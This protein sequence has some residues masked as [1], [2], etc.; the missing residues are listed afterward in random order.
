MKLVFRLAALPCALGCA[1]TAQA[2]TV[3][4]LPTVV[5]SA[6]RTATPLSWQPVSVD[7]ISREALT[8]QQ[9]HNIGEALKALPNVNFGGGPR[10]AGQIP[11]LRGYSGKQITVL[12]DGARAND[13]N[14]LVTPIN[15]DPYQLQNIEVVRGPT[16]ALYGSGGLGGV[17]SFNTVSARDLLV[18]GQNVG[19]D[20]KLGYASADRSGHY[21]ARVYGQYEN[22]DLLASLGY[23]DWDRIRQGGGSLLKPNDGH[24]T[25]AMFKLGIQPDAHQRVQL[26]YMQYEETNLRPNNPQTDNAL[27]PASAIP[28]QTNHTRQDQAI[29]KYSALGDDGLNATEVT[30]YRTRLKRSNDR[31]PA[32]PSLPATW[33]DT[34]TTGLNAKD[35]RRFTTGNLEHRLS[36]GLDYF[37][38][39]QSAASAG[40]PN[41]VLPDGRQ[42][43]YGAFVQDEIRLSPNWSLIPS[44]R[45][46]HYQ[47]SVNSSNQDS[48]DSHVSPK[49]TLNWQARPDTLLYASYGEAYRAP[50][51]TEMYTNLSGRNYLF[52]FAPNPNLRPETDRTLEIGINHQ[53]HGL[54]TANDKLTIKAALFRSRVE[55]LISS[56]VIG[57]YV[58]M[59]PFTG[60][61]VIQQSQNISD[62]SR[63]GAELTAQYQLG[64]SQLG[65]AYSRLRVED[66]NSG[67]QLFSPPDKLTLSLAQALPAGLSAHW[68]SQWVA[69]QD[70]DSTVARR[71][72]GYTVSDVALN[73]EVQGY[74]GVN[75][76]FAVNNLFDKRYVGYQS[77][78]V[79][80]RVPDTG[81]NIKLSLSAA[82]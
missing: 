70:Y 32:F 56:T 24:A 60:V 42:K 78:N 72:A 40:A 7:Q 26:S 9:A 2:Q 64:D 68:R 25:N 4:E 75:V 76:L 73:W 69:A 59:A 65:L 17:I 58:R 12:V 80:A 15:I 31:N 29:L 62:A 67:A 1:W 3:D 71:T 27:G 13:A 10:A 19:A 38:D 81:R 5:V 23:T 33:S 48:Q 43:V 36:Y 37:E 82:M 79:Y 63:R 8:T 45:A 35:T 54:L 50:S 51:L 74:K 28:V 46:D 47:T 14:S 66:Q 30:L 21:N 57:N 44:L 77:S 18:P 52:N 55:D 53:A 11:T 16:S 61:G 6:T 34:T 41:P 49:L 22:I 39:H 20:V